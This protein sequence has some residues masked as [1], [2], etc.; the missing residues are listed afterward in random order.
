MN[1]PVDR[2]YL[3]R[4]RQQS[5]ARAEDAQDPA[6]A[7]IHQEFAQL[8]TNALGDNDGDTD[9]AGTGPGANGDKRPGP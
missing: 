4:R 6:V 1:A 5:L 3:E 8:Y 2:E 9:R 7:R